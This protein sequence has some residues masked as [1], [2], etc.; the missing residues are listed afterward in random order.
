MI[1]EAPI[2][3]PRH[4]VSGMPEE[5]SAVILRALERNPGARWQTAK[6]LARAIEQV[7]GSL[8]FD[9][10]QRAALMRQLFEH[11]MLTTRALLEMADPRGSSESSALPWVEP[12]EPSEPSEPTEPEPRRGTQVLE[13][14]PPAAPPPAE[15]KVRAKKKAASAPMSEEVAANSRAPATQVSVA[16]VH[17]V[18][19]NKSLNLV[20]MGLVVVGIALGVG[21]VVLNET[22]GQGEGPPPLPEASA[23][24]QGNVPQLKE[25]PEPGNPT[26]LAPDAGVPDDGTAVAGGKTA[27]GEEP[28]GEE[29]GGEEKGGKAR[30]AQG[31]M[32]L[33]INPEAEVMVGKKSLGKTPLFN[34]PL[35]VGTHLLRIQGADGKKRRL[36]VP[37]K[38]GE[39]TMLRLGLTDIPEAR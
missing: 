7:G 17:D 19:E 32:T 39:V 10:D 37:I 1:L 16:P 13:E 34:T 26:G 5:L 31:K 30:V 25:F 2:R 24:L 18:S 9:V 6:E 27:P 12:S 22:Q 33:I 29:K 21:F 3:P 35:P 28:K 14:K 38:K 4:M 11:K 36:S 8:L 20:L 23:L 15:K